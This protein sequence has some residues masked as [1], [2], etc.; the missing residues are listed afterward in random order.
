MHKIKKA[1]IHIVDVA[2]TILPI[3]L[4]F[5]NIVRIKTREIHTFPTELKKDTNKYFL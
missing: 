3:S 1:R 5:L 4:F 2:P